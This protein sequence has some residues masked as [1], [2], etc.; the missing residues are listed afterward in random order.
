[1]EYCSGIDFVYGLVRQARIAKGARA[2][3]PTPENF[4]PQNFEFAIALAHFL[5][6]FSPENIPAISPRFSTLSDYGSAV[7]S[8]PLN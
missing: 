4:C 8:Q 1:M 3:T 6:I 7:S 2:A 5:P